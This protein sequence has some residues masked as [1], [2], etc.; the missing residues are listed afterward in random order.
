L[1]EDADQS[2]ITNLEENNMGRTHYWKRTTELPQASF[3]AAMH[4]CKRLLATFTER[5][6]G[7]D[8]TGAAFL[9]RDHIAFNGCL[10]EHGEVFEIARIEFDRRGRNEVASF[11]KTNGLP[12]DVAVQGCLIVLKH[13]LGAKLRVTSD[14]SDC[15]WNVAR[16]AV[17]RL[18]RYGETFK[19]DVVQEE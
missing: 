14:A 6:A 3:E 16:Q 5:V 10:G 17:E 9:A 11:C 15:E 1:V 4:D 12:Y 7:C 18:L 13:H 19:L 2:R 8:G